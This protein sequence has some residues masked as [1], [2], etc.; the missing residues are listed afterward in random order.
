MATQDGQL[1]SFITHLRGSPAFQS[2]V[3]SSGS[4]RQTRGGRGRGKGKAVE[5]RRLTG[6]PRVT[7]G[8]LLAMVQSF[9]DEVSALRTE[10]AMSERTLLERQPS[11]FRYMFETPL[12]TMSFI[13]VP[14]LD[15]ARFP[16]VARSR[17]T[18]LDYRPRT[19]KTRD[20]QTFSD[21]IDP[22]YKAWSI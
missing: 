12:I 20:V 11:N 21:G 2:L 5:P 7:M 9:T 6:E 15:P 10:R 8:T 1:E 13:S 18:N 17:T 14:Y 3:P 19:Y 22:T 4:R 16:S